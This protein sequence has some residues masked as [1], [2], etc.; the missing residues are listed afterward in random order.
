M[1]Q[2]SK[3]MEVAMKRLKESMNKALIYGSNYTTIDWED[4]YKK[5][6]EDKDTVEALK[7]LL[8]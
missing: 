3:Q 8:C 2:S 4:S 6:S 1:L 7:G 5:T